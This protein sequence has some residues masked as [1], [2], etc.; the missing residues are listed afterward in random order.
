MET[1]CEAGYVRDLD[2]VA[3][4]ARAGLRVGELEV[5]LGGRRARNS[6]SAGVKPGDGPRNSPVRHYVRLLEGAVRGC[7]PENAPQ[8]ALTDAPIGIG[9]TL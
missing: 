5:L 3:L 6:S 2:A 9:S 4:L 1:L 8:I 7:A